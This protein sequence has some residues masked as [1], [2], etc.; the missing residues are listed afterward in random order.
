MACGRFHKA[1]K[2]NFITRAWNGFT[3][4]VSRAWN[5]IKN[6][7]GQRVLDNA[8]R[9]ANTGLGIAREFGVNTDKAQ[10]FVDTAAGYGNKVLN[11]ISNY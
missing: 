9:M 1:T 7:G 3:N 10:N 8:Q 11:K 5:W 2:A 4:G 6:G